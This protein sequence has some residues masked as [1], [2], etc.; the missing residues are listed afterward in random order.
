[1][2]CK[3]CKEEHT[4]GAMF[5][6]GVCAYCHCKTDVYNQNGDNITREQDMRMALLSRE[7]FRGMEQGKALV[8]RWLIGCLEGKDNPKEALRVL[9]LRNLRKD[10]KNLVG[11]KRIEAFEKLIKGGGKNE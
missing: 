5:T 11:I 6:T 9:S 7:Y 8:V 10:M 2:K 1:M 3:V 4:A